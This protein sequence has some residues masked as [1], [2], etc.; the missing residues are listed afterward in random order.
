M[1]PA[2][3]LIVLIFN[4]ILLTFVKTTPIRKGLVRHAEKDSTA[5]DLTKILN[6]GAESSINPQFQ[7]YKETLTKKGTDS[8]NG[9][10]VNNKGKYNKEYYEKNKEKFS[11]YRR[12][13]RKQNKQKINEIQRNYSKR[14]KEKCSQRMK[15]YYEKNKE[16]LKKTIKKYKQNNKEKV[17]KSKK[18]YYNNNKE[19]WNE[20]RRKCNQKK[21]NV[22]S[23]NEGTSLVNTQTDNFTNKGKLSNVCEVEETLF[24]QGQECTNG[25]DEQNQIEVEGPNKILEDDTID[26][27]KKIHPFDLNEIPDDEE[28]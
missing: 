13:Y 6:D 18:L 11:E 20:Y 27:N 5:K 10:K 3:F 19:K 25:E 15:I 26:L 17:K 14:N 4:W 28:I 12:N 23:D 16:K 2:R 22:Q 8:Y 24:N 21:K 1:K 7:K 9:D